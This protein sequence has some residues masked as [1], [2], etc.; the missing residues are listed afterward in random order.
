MSAPNPASARARGLGAA[1]LLFCAL[2]GSCRLDQTSSRE[3]KYVTV[4]LN[5][6]LTRY[7]SVQVLIL[8]NGDTNVIVGKAWDGRLNAPGAIPAFRLDDAETRNL[9]IRVKGYDAFGRLS[10]DM[11]IFKL[12]GKQ[13]VTNFIVAKPSPALASLKVA[14]GILTPAFDPAVK[15]YTIHLANN[16]TWLQV[17]MEPVYAQASMFA[18][19][20]RAASGVA[21]DPIDMAI[22]E[23][24]LV[25]NVTTADTSTQYVITATRDKNPPSDTIT[26]PKD[27][28]VADPFAAWKHQALI[29]PDYRQVNLGS[30]FMVTDFPLLLRLDKD[31]FH[32]SEVAPDGRDFRFATASGKILP[33]ELMIWDQ[34]SEARI[35]VKI[36]TLRGRGDTS[37]ILMYWGNP[38]A[39]SASDPAAVF[40]TGL[41][42]TGVYHLEET[43]K[44]DPGEYK[45]AT[46]NFN[47]T[48]VGR[49]PPSR[50]GDAVGYGQDFKSTNTQAVIQLPDAFDPG[51][52]AW[53]MQMWI[54]QEGNERGTIFNKG[55]GTTS[56]QQ[57][58][59]LVSRENDG[60]LMLLTPG[61]NFITQTDLPVDQ[62]LLLG[63]VFDGS[64]V[65]MYERGVESESLTWHQGSPEFAKTFLGAADEKGTTGF[66]GS[67]DEFWVSHVARTPDF[68]RLMYENQKPYSPFV[69]IVPLK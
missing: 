29:S 20:I 13:V 38:A 64:R 15:A 47:G 66:H 17:T 40:P 19:L 16:Q 51:P 34:G 43:G 59:Q 24:R 68:M 56:N 36:D 28:I 69:S 37:P 11:M 10:L 26:I 41:G 46:G 12:D 25:L 32:L 55:D 65:H 31:H 2:L 4:R 1:L 33:Y 9:T 44:G 7:D 52:D 14:P 21:V 45:D 6:S 67:M 49:T 5:D 22:G 30:N 54:K 61:N 53:T 63:L 35:W 62:W 50:K 58:F 42:W 8:A 60:Q 3:E 27:T 57:R 48:G 18:G 39:V 23:N